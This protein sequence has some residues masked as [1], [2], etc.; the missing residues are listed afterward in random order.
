MVR[1]AQLYCI[2]SYLCRQIHSLNHKNRLLNIKAKK[3]TMKKMFVIVMAVAAVA[4][5]ACTGGN[6]EAEATDET[7]VAAVD[8][9]LTD[10]IDELD[11]ALEAEDGDAVQQ[12]IEAFKAKIAELIAQGKTELAQQWSEKL[13]Q[14]VEENKAKIEALSPE[15]AT[16]AQSAVSEV[17]SKVAALPAA[18]VETANEAADAAKGAAADAVDAANQAVENTKAAAEEAATQA[19]DDA[20]QKANDAIDQGVSDVKGKLGL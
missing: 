5:T 1:E 7:E 13:Q 14:F 10:N 6:K 3:E 19:V 20:K 11:A 15:L 2:F 12:S 8:Q 9:E 16:V 4:F 17:V 18:A